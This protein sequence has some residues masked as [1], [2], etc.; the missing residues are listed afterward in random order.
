MKTLV[1]VTL[2]IIAIAAQPSSAGTLAK[3]HG[4]YHWGNQSP[5][6]AFDGVQTIVALGS[7][8]AR[9]SLSPRYNI[10]Y[11][12]GAACSPL[13]SLEALAQQPDIKAALDNPNIDVFMLTAYD[14]T[15]FGDCQTQR[16][17]EPQF[18]RPA[19]V[20][21][22]VREYSDLTL[23]LYRAYAHTYKRFIIS[24][25]ESD[26]SI[27]CGQAYSYATTKSFRDY[28]DEAYPSIYHGNP[29][30]AE[31][32]KALTLWFQFRQQGIADGRV[33]A[34]QAGLGGMRVYFAPKFCI[35]RALHDHGFQSVLYDVLPF[36]MF[37]YVS[38]SAYESINTPRPGDTLTVDL[39]TIRD[40]TGSS[41]II[42]GEIGF[43]RSVWG[44]AAIAR[45]REVLASADTWGISYVFVWNLYDSSTA[46]N[47]GVYG[48]DGM[49]TPLTAYYQNIFQAK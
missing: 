29:T 18:Y 30:P 34:A 36:V 17:L 47:Y 40:V 27:Y 44:E 46:D 25:W 6:S 39:N 22:L 32:V 7:R 41:S 12:Q 3:T 24:N 31:S 38:Y 21:A 26:N 35:T 10:D 5:V 14:F 33:R 43:S 9:I 11:H 2:T 45:T 1:S 16:F 42:L 8:A 48:T 49:R 13:A 19:N 37:D 28:C 15:T 4:F 20:Q 23:Y